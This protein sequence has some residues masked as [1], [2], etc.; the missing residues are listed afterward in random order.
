[1]NT[2]KMSEDLADAF[3]RECVIRIIDDLNRSVNSYGDSYVLNSEEYSH[4]PDNI[5]DNPV[6]KELIFISMYHAIRFFQGE[7]GYPIIENEPMEPMIILK[8]LDGININIA[9]G[10]SDF[11]EIFYEKFKN[12]NMKSLSLPWS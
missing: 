7:M 5:A 8:N 6:I 4:I 1:M 2:L 12:I 9:E 3:L 10:L 11:K